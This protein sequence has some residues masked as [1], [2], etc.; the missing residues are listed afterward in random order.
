[1]RRITILAGGSRGD[2]QPYIAL[3]AGLHAAGYQVRIATD[4]EFKPLINA[5]GLEFFSTDQQTRPFVETHMAEI[6]WSKNPLK[7]M[8][9]VQQLRPELRA[10]E[11]RQSRLQW[12]ACQGASAI[13]GHVLFTPYGLS[14]AEKLDIPYIEVDVK[15][16]VPTR[17]YPLV[18]LPPLRLGGAFNYSSQRLLEQLIWLM[19]RAPVNRWRK[20]LLGLPDLPLRGYYKR[21]VNTLGLRLCGVSPHVVSQPLDWAAHVHMTGYWL[22]QT[23]DAYQ[24]PAPLVKF[25]A[26]GP[27][28]V[29]VGFGS[30]PSQD[31]QA[32]TDLVVEALERAGQRGVLLGGWNGLAKTRLP[33][34]VFHIDAVSH[35]WLFPR[36]AAVV[37]HGGAGTTAAALRA[38]VPAVVVPYLGDQPYWGRMTHELGVG[39]KPLPRKKLTAQILAAALTEVTNDQSMQATAATL[40]EKIR[41]EDG[42][43]R[44]VEEIGR[45]LG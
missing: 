39:A 36:T 25:L 33:E 42:V 23:G 35:A 29:Y 38:G 31:P 1:M 9:R 8:R 13:I 3:G 17:E 5:Q 11:E 32:A 19:Q 7:I 41:A 4:E 34:T 6:F 26:A 21:M 27:P 16:M 28:P 14:M 24:P 22:L 40:G 43:G 2:N 44:A 30:M 37:H 10:A 18:I 12:Q 15:P 20:E 45:Y